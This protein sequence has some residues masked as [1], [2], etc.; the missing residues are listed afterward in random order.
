MAAIVATIMISMVRPV[1]AVMVV[2][3]AVSPGGGVGG[4]LSR[5]RAIRG[6]LAVSH[7]NY[8]RR[9]DTYGG[10][11][12]FFVVVVRV[13]RSVDAGTECGRPNGR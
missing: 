4:T 9:S 6:G 7:H 2:L 5:R 10:I 1:K 11:L 8:I 12:A 13:S 3:F